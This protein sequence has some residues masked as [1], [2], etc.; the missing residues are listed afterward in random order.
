MQRVLGSGS[1]ADGVPALCG[2]PAILLTLCSECG[3]PRGTWGGW[4]LRE[5]FEVF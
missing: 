4:I 5:L 1:S 3:V 2:C